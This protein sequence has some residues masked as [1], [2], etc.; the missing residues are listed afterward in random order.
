MP[1]CQLESI[2]KQFRGQW[3][4]QNLNTRIEPGAGLAITGPNGSG[5]STLLLCLAELVRPDL[6]QVQWSEPPKG[7]PALAAP[8]M[9]LP[10]EFRLGELLDFHFGLNPILAGF[11]PFL[12][13]EASG[14]RASSSLQIRHFS[15]GMTQ[16][17]RLVLALLSDSSLLLLDEPHS[18]LDTHGQTWFQAL[19][20]KVSH[21]RCLVIASND[22]AEYSRCGTV[23]VLQGH[24]G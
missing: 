14:L 16:K 24:N 19:L 1:V 6:G 17:L 21:N 2:G 3:L 11:D 15:S 9:E 12:E 23:L 13:L 18:H 20:P 22:P 4:F 8:S 5:K 7:R 10:G